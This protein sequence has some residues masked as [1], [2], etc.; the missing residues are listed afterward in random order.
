MSNWIRIDDDTYIDDSLVTCAEYQLFIDEM[1]TNRGLFHQPDHWIN[2]H[3]SKG[4]SRQPILGVRPSD[5][6]DFCKWLTERQQSDWKYRLLSIEETQEYPVF[7][8]YKVPIGYWIID[9]KFDWIGPIPNN[10][11]IVDSVINAP[12]ITLKGGID[13]ERAILN[14]IVFDIRQARDRN[15]AKE[16]F[17][18]RDRIGDR[19][20]DLSTKRNRVI[21]GAVNR[22]RIRFMNEANIL[23]TGSRAFDVYLTFLILH[24]RI[25]GTSP[26]FEGIRLVR[27]R[28]K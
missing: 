8:A 7:N 16:L 14:D 20:I 15:R 2:N 21:L 25:A 27:E 24:E 11:P 19:A 5:A 28:V 18:I 6:E 4:Q 12:E 23:S 13:I 26:A 22:T 1:R 9:R 17:A 10:Q 3:F